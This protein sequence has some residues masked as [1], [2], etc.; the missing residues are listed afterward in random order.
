MRHLVYSIFDNVFSATLNSHAPFKEKMIRGNHKPFVSKILRKEIMKRA[1]L[2]NLFNKS[3]SESDFKKYKQQR[4]LV[5]ALNRKEKKSFFSNIEI[6]TDKKSFWKACK[7]FLS[8]KPTIN[9]EKITLLENGSVV[10]DESSLAN[11]FNNYFTHITES[12]DISYW[13]GPCVYE[14]D[15]VLSAITKYQNH[16]SIFA[17]KQNYNSSFEFSHITPDIVYKNILNIKKGSINVPIYILKSVADTCTPYLRT[18]CFNNSLNN[19]SFPD[20]MKWADITPVYK[21]GDST[22]KGNYRP[23][24][25]LPTISKVFERIIY[26]QMYSFFQN[27]FS[28]FLGGFRKGFSVQ[29]SLA[30]LLKKWQDCLDKKGVIGTVLIDLSKAFDCIQH[31]LLIAKLAAYGFSH[32]SL[33]FIFSYLRNRKQRVKLGSFFGSWLEVVLGVP[34]GSILGPLLFNIFINDLF[35]IVK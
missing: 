31:D 8:S 35:L 3:H 20:E 10:S 9:S 22:D 15:P 27:L 26:D 21:K 13:K 17:I 30:R 16:P 19:C 24:S 2:K 29:H 33:S 32:K 18:D 25:N 14:N 4:N 1:R 6:S 7:P 28:F 23:I 11:I 12:L 34:Q 5:V